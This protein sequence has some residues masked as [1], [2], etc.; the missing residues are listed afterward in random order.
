MTEFET[1]MEKKTRSFMG[2]NVKYFVKYVDRFNMFLNTY[3]FIVY[4]SSFINSEVFFVIDNITI[5]YN[6]RSC[7]VRQ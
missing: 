7:N 2:K 5:L 1:F 6:Y 4:I 3:I